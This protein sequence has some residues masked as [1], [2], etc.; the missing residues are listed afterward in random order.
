M[1]RVGRT[2]EREA[3]AVTFCADRRI[4]RRRWTRGAERPRPCLCDAS[5]ASPDASVSMTRSPTLLEALGVGQRASSVETRQSRPSEMRPATL[6]ARQPDADRI[7]VVRQ[8][9]VTAEPQSTSVN[10]ASARDRWL[11]RAEERVHDRACD[12]LVEHRCRL[13]F[14]S[15]SD[16]DPRRLGVEEVGDL[17]LRSSGGSGNAISTKSS[18][19]RCLGVRTSADRPRSPS[20]R[21]DSE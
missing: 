11:S 15:T 13:S 4:G 8:S 2:H 7:A 9:L 3:I 10:H 17:A 19:L 6:I 5:A 21:S 1:R 18:A 16:V 14:L 12:S 20:A